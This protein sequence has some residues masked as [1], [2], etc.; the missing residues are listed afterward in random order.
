[1]DKTNTTHYNVGK[2][3]SNLLHPLTLNDYSLT[4]SF[5]TVT[6]INNIPKHLFREGYQFVSFDFYL[7]IAL[8]VICVACSF[9]HT[10]KQRLVILI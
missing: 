7:Y 10:D 5:D 6:Q 8:I 9:R 4:D 1:M 3:L 2:F